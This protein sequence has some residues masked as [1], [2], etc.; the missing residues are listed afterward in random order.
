MDVSP[1]DGGRVQVG[2]AVSFS[3]P[4]FSIFGQC[5]S[6]RLE[7]KPAAGYRFEHWNGDLSG[8]TNPTTILMDG[9]KMVTASFSRI[10]HKL[11]IQVSGSGIT[12]PEADDYNYFQG[13][14]VDITAN[15]DSG[16]R[17]VNWDGDVAD[18][19]SRTTAVTIDADKTVTANFSPV[20]Y[21]RW[22]VGGIVAGGAIIGLIIWL[23]LRRR[24]V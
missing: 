12:T 3:F 4:Y 17:F 15:P 10:V 14:A 22:S 7:A 18:P 9:N 8:S 16:W 1:G 5:E 21:N 11:T 13:A 23:S 6:V 19:G 24:A 20:R 2:K